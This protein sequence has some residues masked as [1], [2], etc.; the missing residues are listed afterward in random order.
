M[1]HCA[2]AVTVT[3]AMTRP[4]MSRNHR[5]PTTVARPVLLARSSLNSDRVNCPAGN[6]PA[7]M[8]IVA[9]TTRAQ[10]LRKPR[11][12]CSARPTQE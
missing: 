9:E 4:T 5:A 12:G 3:P 8:K 1:I 6:E 2:L 7:T 11:A 10:P